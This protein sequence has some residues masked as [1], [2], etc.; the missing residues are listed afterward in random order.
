[1]KLIFDVAA[2]GCCVG[3]ALL[4]VELLKGACGVGQLKFIFDV[5]AAG[6]CVGLALLFVALLKGALLFVELL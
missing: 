2:G 5:A 3:L 1:L 6:G 4:F